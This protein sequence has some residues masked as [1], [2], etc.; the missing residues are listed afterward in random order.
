MD[1]DIRTLEYDRWEDFVRAVFVS[2]GE[3]PTDQDIED[4]RIEFEPGRSIAAFDGD[5]IVG[6]TSTL[7]L[8]MTVPGGGQVPVAGVTTVGVAPTHRRRGML[9]AMMRR[10]LD[11][12]REHGDAVAALW[13]SEAPIYQRFGY[14]MATRQAVGRV[15]RANWSFLR[16]FTDPGRVRLL[17]LEDAAKELAPVYDRV[18]AGTPG[19]IEQNQDWWGYL[20]RHLNA[21][22]H[23]RGFGE[24]FF[25]LHEG[26]E[27]PDAYAVY[28]VKPQEE[29]GIDVGQLQV[30][31]AVTTTP[32]SAAAM[33]SFL[34]GVD[35]IATIE[36][37]NRPPDDP[38]FSMALELRHLG[39][40]IIDGMWVR[41]LDVPAAL[42]AR[43]YGVEGRVVFDLE[44][45]FCPWN[46]GRYELSGGPHGAE[47]RPADADADLSFTANEL[48]AVYLG[49]TR[50]R[51][52]DR[53]GRV[54]ELTDG[55]VVRADAMF[56][57]DREPWCP[58]RF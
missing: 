28:R 29:E 12:S 53:A 8:Q 16:P 20:F 54:R 24:L 7:S 33:W 44:D 51:D 47:C 3:H 49:G 45:E 41:V 55:A 31:E 42:S 18:R 46:T 10:Q 48:G 4:S 25:A 58:R 36:F 27:G 13:A 39:L 38:L 19:M 50:L 5:L 21:E 34:F 14:G 6:T 56:A 37:G 40:K 35:L 1:F 57:G 23:R 2:F 30:A 9:R 17:P 22:H 43:R 15:S 52:L 26:E 32:A 11:D